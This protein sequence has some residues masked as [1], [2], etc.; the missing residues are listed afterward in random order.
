MLLN[1]TIATLADTM[2]DDIVDRDE[3]DFTDPENQKLAKRKLE[4]WLMR[5]LIETNEP[6]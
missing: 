1:E 5:M 3:F 2:Y 6:R 4:Y